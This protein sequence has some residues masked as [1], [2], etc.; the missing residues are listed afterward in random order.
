LY[1]S[2]PLRKGMSIEKHIAELLYEH[3]CVIIPGFGGFVGNYLHAR[4]HP[5]HHTFFPPAKSLL[6][7]VNLKQ[8]DGLLASRI[9]F[10]ENISYEKAVLSVEDQVAIWNRQL[11]EQTWLVLDPIG[12]LVLN[13]EGSVQFEQDPGLNF[14]QESFGLASF[15]SPAIKRAGFQEKLEKRINRYMEAPVEHRRKLPKQLKWAAML[16]IPVGLATY[17]GITNFDI[18]RNLKINY[19]GLFYS[20]PAS[21]EVKPGPSPK[22]YVIEKPAHILPGIRAMAHKDDKIT[23]TV[24]TG[25]N[26]ITDQTFKPSSEPFAIIIGAFRIHENADHLVKD[27]KQKGFDACILDTTKTGLFRVSIG[28]YPDRERALQELAVVRSK[29]FSA[30]WLLSR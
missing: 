17:F 4:I 23:T 10:R 25:S 1:F 29:E 27:L 26:I 11:R 22:T 13:R 24:Q 15:V 9:S 5:V 2:A 3:D 12:R 21:T 28:T 30:A 19:S 14:L 20:F 18:I 8:N 6:F 16:M 7:N